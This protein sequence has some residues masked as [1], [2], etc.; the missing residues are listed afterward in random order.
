MLSKQFFTYRRYV[1]IGSVIV[2]ISLVCS[3]FL[4]AR[5]GAWAALRDQKAIHQI[6]EQFSTML[7]DPQ[8]SVTD[9]ERQFD[10]F[11]KEMS[12]SAPALARLGEMSLQIGWYA[13]GLR[14]F[15]SAI[16]LD[17]KETEYQIQALYATSLLHEGSLP[18]DV[19]PKAILLSEQHPEAYAL[20]NLLA[21]HAYFTGEP[22]KAI[23]YWQ[24]CLLGDKALAPEKKAGL[25]KAI[26]RAK[27]ALRQRSTVRFQVQLDLSEAHRAQLQPNDQ[28]FIA[29]RAAELDMPP[30]VVMKCA[31]KDLPQVYLLDDS[32]AMIELP[33]Y[34][35]VP[36]V[37]VIAKVEGAKESYRISSGKFPVVPGDN[38]VKL[39]L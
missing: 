38:A 8:L 24:Q 28:I 35:R 13:R 2:L 15:E 3:A 12:H 25:E 7:Q 18:A 10:V 37:E 9:L 11:A 16:A 23:Q 31:V 33:N 26:G 27:D 39:I 34:N 20:K 36:S 14:L 30:L 4:Y 1:I 17:P 6:H 19:I 32:N 22:L 29:V 5:W 21:I